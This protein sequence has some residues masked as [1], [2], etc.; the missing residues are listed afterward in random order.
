M[1]QISRCRPLRQPVLKMKE[2]TTC[3]PLPRTTTTPLNSPEPH[4][5]IPFP[6]STTVASSS[7]QCSHHAPRRNIFS[8]P[9]CPLAR[10][11]TATLCRPLCPSLSP[12]PTFL[13]TMCSP[14][15]NKD[16]TGTNRRQPG[17]NKNTLNVN[18]CC[19]TKHKNRALLV[20]LRRE[21]QWEKK[22]TTM[23]KKC[24]FLNC[25]TCVDAS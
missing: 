24:L 10:Q 6:M 7:H 20:R 23:T 2:E 4:H 18:C 22:N 21:T 15:K 16:A 3:C 13:R 8:V 1:Q 25:D 17:K 19:L 9:Q 14:C 5:T 12:I 11:N